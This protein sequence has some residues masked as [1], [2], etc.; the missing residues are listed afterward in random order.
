MP[1]VFM[2]KYTLKT[3]FRTS[4]SGVVWRIEA[5]TLRGLMAV[6]TR[7][8]D[9]G[10]PLFSVF[11]YVSG[12]SHFHEIS[13]GD[14]HWT[15]AGIANGRLILRAYGTQSPDSPGIACID[16][17]DGTVVWEQF[18][19][20]LLTVMEDALLVRHRN[21]STGYETRLQIADGSPMQRGIHTPPTTVPETGLLVPRIYNG[22]TPDFLANYAIEGEIHH[23]ETGAYQLW[24]FH[25]KTDQ[26]YRIRLVVSHASEIAGNIIAITGLTKMIPELFF[27]IGRQ[28]FLIGNNKREIVSYLL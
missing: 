15:L 23:C 5:D 6:E 22:E 13:Y 16:A 11:A 2:D 4:F 27:M 14:R 24:G 10:K 25:E 18:N 9:S 17:L 28:I 7:E 26:T 20:T 8:T 1:F 21:F 19:Y 12:Q 3:V